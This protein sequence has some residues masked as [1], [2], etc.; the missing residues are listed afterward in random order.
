MS[1]ANESLMQVPAWEQILKL[2]GIKVDSSVFPMRV[3]CP[4]CNTNYLTIYHNSIHS[5]SHCKNC[6]FGGDSIEFVAAVLKI[7]TDAAII[8][9]VEVGLLVQP[10]ADKLDQYNHNY[11]DRKASAQNLLVKS[12]TTSIGANED[13]VKLQDKLGYKWSQHFHRKWERE[14]GPFVGPVST[15]GVDATFNLGSI[16]AAARRGVSVTEYVGRARIFWGFGWG[17]VLMTPLYRLPGLLAGFFFVGRDGNPETDYVYKSLTYKCNI[18]NTTDNMGLAII[19]AYDA[20][21]PGQD[22][23]FAVA[24]IPLAIRMQARHYLDNKHLLPIVGL[25]FK[26]NRTS[27]ETFLSMPKQNVVF[28]APSLTSEIYNQAKALN[29]SI[30]YRQLT[31]EVFSHEL[32]QNFKALRPFEWIEKFKNKSLSWDLVLERHLQQA[33][34]ALAEELLLSI[35]FTEDELGRFLLHCTDESR[36]KIENVLSKQIL[37]KSVLVDGILIDEKFDGWYLA[38]TNECICNAT[39][40]IDNVIWS[41]NSKDI[42]YDGH[43]KYKGESIKFLEKETV[44]LSKSEHFKRILLKSGKGLLH[45]HSKWENKLLEIASRFK[46]PN[47]ITSTGQV[48]WNERLNSFVLPKFAISAIDGKI[49]PNNFDLFGENYPASKLEYEVLDT[50]EMDSLLEDSLTNKVIWSVLAC[51]AHNIIAPA[52]NQPVFGIA[53]TGEGAVHIGKSIAR[54]VGCLVYDIKDEEI[55]TSIKTIDKLSAIHNWPIVLNLP[56][57]SNKSLIST[58]IHDPKNCIIGMSWYQAHAAK[59]ISGWNV[60]SCNK[61]LTIGDNKAGVCAKVLLNYLQW[62]CSKRLQL[63]PGS[64]LVERTRVDI[65]AFVN[66]STN[67]MQSVESANIVSHSDNINRGGYNDN[68]ITIICKM[69]DDGFLKP[70]NGPG[71]I[72]ISLEDINRIMIA[73]ELPTIDFDLVYNE[74]KVAGVLI[75]KSISNKPGWSVSQEWF[76]KQILDKRNARL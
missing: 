76:S 4:L 3:K 59:M 30:Y 69:F 20:V 62:L 21:I 74:L 18:A 12:R 25:P 5:W 31:D 65:T 48:G 53:L 50:D 9:L 70:I 45:V 19:E 41:D 8:K 6:K 14:I 38:D 46:S 33:R 36:I 7:S 55:H 22:C 26:K 71:V 49:G 54:A 44:I 52:V 28:W 75:E 64:T 11:L 68:A 2:L 40:G 60:I 10:N 61:H 24:D 13:L 34:P 72:H 51:L 66:S 23:L 17:D 47:I 29:A 73:E 16:D 67:K 35:D 42:Y 43:I 1:F 37:R 39:I 27:L 15:E 56:K 32:H 57:S 63:M 58:L